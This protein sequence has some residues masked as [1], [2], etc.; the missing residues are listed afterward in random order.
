[1]NEVTQAYID[2][3]RSRMGVQSY[4]KRPLVLEAYQIA[5]EFHVKTLEGTM[6]G[7]AN[8]YVIVGVKNELYVCDEEI[9]KQLYEFVGNSDN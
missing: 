6:K 3:M 9:F 5:H 1:M 7:K 2:H 4:R 8:D